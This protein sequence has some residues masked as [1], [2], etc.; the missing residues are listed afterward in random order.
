MAKRD[1]HTWLSKFRYSIADYGYYI[2][3]NKVYNNVDSIKIELNILNS[4]IG[5]KNIESDFEKL[6]S[7]YPETLKCIPILLAVR[8]YEI[9]AGE[10]GDVKLYTFN[11]QVNTISDYKMFM[12][13]TGLFD[14]LSN[15]I[16]NNLYDYVTGVETGLDSNGRKNRGGHQMEDL[17]ES[18]IQKAGF[19]R[20]VNYFKEMYVS[21]VSRKWN[22][23]LSAVSNQGKMEKR[24]DFVVKTDN[25]IYLIET[26]FYGSGG[27]KLNETARSYKTIAT[28][29]KNVKGAKFVWFTDGAGW[30]S[31]ARNL[32]ETFD[33][34]DDIYSINDMQNGIMKKI[35]I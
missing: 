25:C 9:F 7:K 29:M 6:I 24:W 22:I 20:D 33:V 5:S 17:V 2:D 13:K 27:S 21:E 23:D 11:K 10:N 30:K 19:K 8:E 34:L 16:I 4:L 18:Y 32:E 31:A 35:F 28:E 26:N 15:H 3:F 12:N 14:L 1:F